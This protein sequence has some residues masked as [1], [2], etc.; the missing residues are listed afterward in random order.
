MSIELDHV[1]VAV[2]DLDSGA[3][4]VE[5]RHGLASVEGGRHPGWGTANRIVPL[6]DTY[7]ELIAVVDDA[8]A[9]GS[10]FGSWVGARATAGGSL[11]GWAVRTDELDAVADRLGL[12]VDAKSRKDASGRPL[13]WRVAGI[14]E[15][16]AEPPLPFFLEWGDG[17]PFPGSARVEHPRGAVRIAQLEI[18]GD[19]DRVERWLGGH[20][21]PL[22]VHAGAPGILTLLLT[23]AAGDFALDL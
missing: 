13:H 9:S 11:L 16:V 17:T 5:E 20:A 18:A 3:R 15:A 23:G 1:V 19:A 4:A 12:A 2:S 8:E 14:P 10:D 21:L 6:G 7:V 22:T